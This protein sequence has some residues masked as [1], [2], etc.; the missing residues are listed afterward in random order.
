MFIAPPTP[1]NELKAPPPDQVC[2]QV[3]LI[4]WSQSLY[5]ERGRAAPLPPAV[6]LVACS[7]HVLQKKTQN[8]LNTTKKGTHRISYATQRHRN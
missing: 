6:C 5:P 7:G 1:N 2:D 8:K 4:S 3:T